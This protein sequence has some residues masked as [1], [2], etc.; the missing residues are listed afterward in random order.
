MSQVLMYI[1]YLGHLTILFLM[2]LSIYFMLS[3]WLFFF[4]Y[5]SF[6]SN[7]DE[8]Y[9]ISARSKASDTV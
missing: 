7:P 9:F 8:K 5:T 3:F 1:Y 4:L 2:Q 6:L